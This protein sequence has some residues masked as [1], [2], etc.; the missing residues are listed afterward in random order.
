MATPTITAPGSNGNAGGATAA[1]T[2]T[3]P[4]T[5]PTLLSGQ[6]RTEALTLLATVFLVAACGLIYELLL[7]TISA[8]LL[9]SSVTQ[10]SLCIGAF[11]GAM[12]VGSYLSQ[13]V[14]RGLLRLFLLIEVALGAVGGL[15]AW[16]LFAAYTTGNDLVYYGALF[17]LLLV[18]GGLSGIE[19]PLLTRLLNRYG[20]LRT[21]IAQAL[22]FDYVG[23][24][25]GSV[26]F[27]LL[28]LPTLGTMRT[29]FLVGLL[30]IGV[31]AYNVWVFRHRLR[32]PAL[33]LAL[34]GALAALLA[35]GRRGLRKSILAFRAAAVRR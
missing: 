7:A 29:A 8:Y 11:I 17:G 25:I 5:P 26:A 19:L 28:L 13:F 32:A 12:G 4:G 6:D 18:I 16:A 31:A 30:N 35:A 1:A 27:P 20:A 3:E 14:Q 22:S 2:G 34:C 33:P 15:S 23:A 10:F 9:G 24:L 21:V